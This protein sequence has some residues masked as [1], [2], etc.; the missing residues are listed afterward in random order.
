[1]A[2]I[3]DQCVSDVRAGRETVEGCL[4]AHTDYRDDLEPLLAAALAMRAPTVEPD[5]ARKLKARHTFVET[6][7]GEKRGAHRSRWPLSTGVV[8][9]YLR[10]FRSM[11]VA[12]FALN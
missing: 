1:M 11:R 6:I 3:L 8:S 5:P 12:A 10:G 9:D 7:A 4:A 2:E